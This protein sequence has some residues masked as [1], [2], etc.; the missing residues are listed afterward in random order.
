MRQF[1]L[2]LACAL[3]A[4]CLSADDNVLMFGND[5]EVSQSDLDAL[6]SEGPVNARKDVLEDKDKILKLLR[7]TFLI[8]ALAD[9]A[10]ENG[11]DKDE[12]IQAKLQ[13]QADK[14]L[15]LERM[16]QID[17]QPLPDFEQA[18][19]EQYLSNEAAHTVPEKV[20][21][22]HILIATTDKLPV[23]HERAEALEIAKKVKK[24]LDEGRSFDDLIKLYS[25]DTSTKKNHGSLGIF[26]RGSMVKPIEDAVFAMH[27]PGETS[28][29]IE[30]QFGFHIIKLLNRFK[31][32][33]LPYEQERPKIIEKLKN[34]YIQNRREVYFDE[35]LKKKHASIYEDLVEAYM[36]ESLESLS[37]Q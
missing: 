37:R 29:I 10:R 33:K 16:K 4:T 9:E 13:R 36:T 2:G 27:E 23:Y 31:P 22:K 6:L 28:D 1:I 30:S 35:L 11:L 18:A 26:S 12:L 25:E 19:K 14:I 8:R 20:S 17:A 3:M 34:E 7:Q 21:A 15:Y 5:I 32:M 24:E